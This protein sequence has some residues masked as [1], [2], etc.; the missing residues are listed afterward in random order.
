MNPKKGF[1]FFLLDVFST[2]DII[3]LVYFE[4][5]DSFLFQS[6][7]LSLDRLAKIIRTFLGRKTFLF[8]NPR[9]S[10][11]FFIL[12]SIMI[13]LHRMADYFSFQCLSSLSYA[14]YC[15]YVLC[16]VHP[17][18]I[19]YISIN[20]GIEKCASRSIILIAKVSNI[21]LKRS[22]SLSHKKKFLE[23]GGSVDCRFDQKSEREEQKI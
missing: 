12:I 9:N 7:P 10:N 2:A 15:K 20:R 22:D 11:K 16:Y 6:I 1:S 18:Y 4:N 13:L 17:Y 5:R 23:D 14:V 19:L 8:L 21:F 3:I